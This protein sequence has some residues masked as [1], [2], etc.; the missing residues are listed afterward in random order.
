MITLYL[1]KVMAEILK[2][3]DIATKVQWGTNKHKQFHDQT[4]C[5]N[6]NSFARLASTLFGG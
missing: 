4:D 3:G 6:A 2:N 1:H 5:K